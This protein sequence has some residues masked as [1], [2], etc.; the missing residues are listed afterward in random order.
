MLC[1]VLHRT[2]EIC[3]G[4][5]LDSTHNLMATLQTATCKENQAGVSESQESRLL[6]REIGQSSIS[7][8]TTQV[9]DED[10]ASFQEASHLK[11]QGVLLRV[12]WIPSYCKCFKRCSTTS[13]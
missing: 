1:D 11:K 10:Q 4:Q 9:A 5:R 12:Y 2:T 8:S 13:T 6:P 7:S 3:T